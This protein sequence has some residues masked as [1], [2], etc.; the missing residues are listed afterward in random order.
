MGIVTTDFLSSTGV[1]K[2]FLRHDNENMGKMILTAHVWRTPTKA[3]V[4]RFRDTKIFSAV[5][6]LRKSCGDRS[7]RA[8]ELYGFLP[9]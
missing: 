7:N 9:Y 5:C 1:S 4:R 2:I 3:R 6:A 8:N